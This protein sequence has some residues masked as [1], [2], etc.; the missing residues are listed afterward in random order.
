MRR[1]LLH[2]RSLPISGLLALRV[3]YLMASVLSCA[4]VASELEAIL[5][6]HLLRRVGTLSMK[7]DG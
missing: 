1:G 7:C 4:I 3:Q 2:G 5:S 6:M